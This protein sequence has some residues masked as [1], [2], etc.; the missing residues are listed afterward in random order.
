MITVEAFEY[1]FN[2][3]KRGK[4]ICYHEGEYRDLVGLSDVGRY[5]RRMNECGR[6][7]LVQKKLVDAPRVYAY[8]AI[9]V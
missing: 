8:Y 4:W 7:I 6:A 9:K 1:E 3:A 5:A 2:N